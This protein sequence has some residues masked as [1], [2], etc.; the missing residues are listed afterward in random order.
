MV[1]VT[2]PWSKRSISSLVSG[3]RVWKDGVLGCKVAVHHTWMDLGEDG[4]A[5]VSSSA[6]SS[7]SSSQMV[8]L[9]WRRVPGV[10]LSSAGMSWGSVVL[11]FLEG[12][13]ACGGLDDMAF[14]GSIYHQEKCAAGL[15]GR[16]KRQRRRMKAMKRFV[17]C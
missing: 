17:D 11:R 3:V 5:E 13:L 10:R 12:V 14:K 15:A 1:S 4:L 16:T 9:T 7:S 8:H 6:A 2:S